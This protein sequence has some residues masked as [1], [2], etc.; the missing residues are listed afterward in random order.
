MIGSRT[1]L[2][3]GAAPLSTRAYHI[4]DGFESV[5]K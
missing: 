3:T 1:G 4:H 2:I 5:V